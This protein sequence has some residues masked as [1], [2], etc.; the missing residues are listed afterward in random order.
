MQ[1]RITVKRHLP[2]T[3]MAAIR[4]QKTAGV[5]KDVGKPG[6]TASLVGGAA[7]GMVLEKLNIE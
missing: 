2:P 4:Q 1:I 5:G 7:V 6:P 3:R